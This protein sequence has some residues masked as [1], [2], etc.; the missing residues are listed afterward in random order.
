[1]KKY[2]F[3]S[4]A[5]IFAL[6]LSAFTHIKEKPQLTDL[7]W[8]QIS[9]QY[10]PGQAIAQSDAK[11]LVQ[12]VNPPIGTACSGTTYDC[13]AGFDASQVNSSNQLINDGQIP[14]N[15]ASKKDY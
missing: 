1:M 3:G 9:N 2:F 14:K 11:F 7:Y 15:V 10:I 4:I 8:F 12:S 13:V 6:G 5:T